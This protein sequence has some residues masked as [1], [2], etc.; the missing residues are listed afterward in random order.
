MSSFEFPEQNRSKDIVKQ[1]DVAITGMACLFPGAP[2]L[3]T[4]WQNIVSK[5]DAITDP[6]SEAWDPDVYHDP[7][8]TE[9][10]RVYCKRGGF[11]GPLAHFNPLKYSVM[12]TAVEGGEPDQW[13]ALQLAYDALADAGYLDRPSEA[14]RTAVILGKGTYLNR[15]NLNM[16]QRGLVVDQTLEIVK[17]LLPELTEDQLRH[18]RQELR[19]GL[20]PFNTE[21]ASALIP[22]IIVGRIAN[23]LDLMGPCYTVDGACASSLLAI[24]IAMRDLLAKKIDLAIVGGAQVST[25]VPIVAL[26]C[27]INALSRRQQ[28]RPFDE[29]ADGTIL[30]EG[31][32]IIVLKRRSDAERDRNRI[33]ALIKGVGSSNDGRGLS[34][35]APRIEGEE[36]ALRRAY[37]MAGISPRT[38]GLIEAHGTGTPAGDVTEIQALSRVFGSQYGKPPWCAIG[39]VKSMI[40]HTM[41]AAGIAGVIKAA[42]S[43]YHKVLPPTINVDKPNPKL[44]LEK[45]P[46]YIN[47]ETRP[48]IHGSHKAPRRAGVNAFGFGGINA[49]IVLE[50]YTNDDE[51]SGQSYTHHWESEVFILEG[52]SRSAL[53]ERAQHLQRILSHESRLHLKDLAFS[54]NTELGE[55]A[56]RLALVASSMT[57]LKK[58]LEYAMSRLNDESCKKIKDI[59]GIYFLDQPLSP[60]NK[61]AFLFPGE[62]AQYVNMLA[63]LCIYFPEVRACFDR[64]DGIFI[65]H[66]RGYLPSDFTFPPPVFSVAE[67]KTAEERIWKMD[68]AIEAVLAANDALFALLNHLEIR[69]DMILGHS[70]GE[71]SAL[72]ASGIFSLSSV[73]DNGQRVRE[74]NQSYEQVAAKGGIPH[75]LVIAV[76]ADSE[77]MASL[78]DPIDAE[79]YIGM[80]NCPHQT[81]IVGIEA[82]IQKAIDELNRQG[83]IY[84]ILPFDR[85][86]HTPLF[87]SYTQNLQQL[88]D[89]WPV[90]SPTI[91][92]YSCATSAPY[93]TNP[94]DIRKLM[95]ETWIRS[96]D[97]QKTIEKMYE[98]GGRIFLEVG[99]KGNLTAFVD[100]ILRGRNHIAVPVNVEHRPG[101]TQINHMVGILAAHGVSMKLDYLYRRRAPQRVSLGKI[102]EEREKDNNMQ[103]MGRKLAIGSP[104]MRISSE[105][106]KR[107]R[108]QGSHHQPDSKGL[109]SDSSFLGNQTLSRPLAPPLYEGD[110]GKTDP[111]PGVPSQ[112]DHRQDSSAQ[113]M[114][115][116]F[117]NMER[118]LQVQQDIM[119]AFLASAAEGLP[120]DEKKHINFS[121]DPE[122]RSKAGEVASSTLP[123]LSTTPLQ[124]EDSPSD[125]LLAARGDK[126]DIPVIRNEGIHEHLQTLDQK[127]LDI[128][129]KKTGYPKE[130]LNLNLDMEADLGIDSI[131]RIEIL[132]AFSEQHGL[133]LDQNMEQFAGL[134][135]LQQVIDFLRSH[136]ET[137]GCTSAG[138]M[139]TKDKV[140]DGN[141]GMPLSTSVKPS[142][143]PLIGEVI[144]MVPGHELVARRRVSLDEDLYLRD[145]TLWGNISRLDDTLR[146]LAV[147]PLTMSMEILAEAGAVIIP[148][149]VLIGMKNIRAYRWIALENSF[150]TLQIV[151]RQRTEANNEVEVKIHI[152]EEGKTPSANPVVEGTMVFGSSYPEPPVADDFSLS[153]ERASRWTSGR[154]YTEGMFHGPCWQGVSSI[155]RCGEDGAIA[156]LEVLASNEFFSSFRNPGFVTDPIVLDAAGQIVGF[157]TKEHLETSFIV[158][159]FRLKALHIFRPQLPVNQKVKCRARIRLVG[160]QQVSSN[161][162]I[163]GDDG[164]LWMRLEEWEDKRFDLPTEAYSF[165]LSP[166]KVIPNRRWELPVSSFSNS[167]LC[168]CFRSKMLFLRDEPFWR[169]VFAHLILNHN[170]RETF[171]KLGKSEKRRTQWLMGRSVA[172]DAV[173]VLLKQHYDIELGPA[174]VEIG[175]DEYGRP[176]PQ[177]AWAQTIELVP[178]LS[179]AHTNGIAVAIAGLLNPDQGIGID[180]EQ[181]RSL[182]EG[183]ETTAFTPEELDLLNSVEVSARQQWVIRLWCAKEAL[184]KALGRGLIQGPQSLIVRELNIHTGDVKTALQGNLAAEFPGFSQ[185]AVVVHTVLEENYIV[186]STICERVKH[187]RSD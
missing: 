15:G 129:S 9:E 155:D 110:H 181:V 38:I 88:F 12:P 66:A 78:I 164:R 80:N 176:V 4:Y 118:F 141:A 11:I 137:P 37:E 97:F 135:T 69:P 43:L 31:I 94:D 167:S 103:Q 109:S 58:K 130:I 108:N 139:E 166:I 96:V 100:D 171:R 170:E 71:Y 87:Q 106:A 61:I 112:Q 124:P 46:F 154:L 13:L 95:V 151:A 77:R 54:L 49:H 120:H 28:I 8:S 186:A 6:P 114:S 26:F 168:L 72:S 115:D 146:P 177:G 40:S 104:M 34:V 30:G 157:W 153:G 150:V 50:E 185:S 148:E 184:A 67:R 111:A 89:S 51:A 14:H 143:F 165:L 152:L 84:Q 127:L 156:T 122:H 52:K 10:D 160:T 126:P 16:V 3:Q 2:D 73:S 113:V 107:L 44:E 21:T 86:Y 48:W 147:M 68:G 24:E 42:L 17:T 85:P 117:D 64:L 1:E 136:L 149:Q 81:I 7:D 39:S 22:N 138:Q 65:E 105:T 174:D 133:T 182:E 60:E 119:Q 56:Y 93:P 23:R 41:P 102:S 76:G 180:I 132:G 74:L 82:E 116:Y 63:D 183:F 5:V 125:P 161:F 19:Q 187:A 162:D 172:K 178:V 32:G 101:I 142:S 98:D 83:L 131:K 92:I 33:Y 57:D 35:L 59:K 75:A 62:G 159:P 79:I 90:H 140:E 20:P 121:A 18:I 70:T 91:Q 123:S 179:L 163:I 45:T 175:Q 99:P 169:Q 29:D 134:K 55:A 173:R 27:Q 25:W 53:I 36:L 145:H 158:F 128:V 144:S 47:T